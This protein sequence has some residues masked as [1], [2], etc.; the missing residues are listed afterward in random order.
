MLRSRTGRNLVTLMIAA[1]LVV[2]A[3]GGSG[4]ETKVIKIGGLATLEGPFAVPGQDGFRGIEQALNTYGK[5]L[6][7][8]NWSYE[9]LE[10]SCIK[11]GSDATPGGRPREGQEAHRAGRRRHPDRPA[12][13]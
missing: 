2:S 7:N 6:E 5:K 9:G 4:S 13:R 11:E 12:L 10:I 1:G 3:C 8:G